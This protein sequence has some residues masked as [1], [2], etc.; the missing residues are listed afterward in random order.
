MILERSDSKKQLTP[1][2]L[3]RSPIRQI[4]QVWQAFSE[5]VRQSPE[6]DRLTYVQDTCCGQPLRQEFSS[7]TQRE[8]LHLRTILRPSFHLPIEEMQCGMNESNVTRMQKISIP[9]QQE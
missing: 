7:V 2:R 5:R 3:V 6:P 1:R 4:Q 8:L 9:C